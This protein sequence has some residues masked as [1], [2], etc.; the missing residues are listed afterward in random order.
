[1]PAQPLG[2]KTVS[3]VGNEMNSLSCIPKPDSGF[4]GVD[5]KKEI[6]LLIYQKTFVHY[7][8]T[9]LLHRWLSW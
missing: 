2:V 3:Q 6:W 9:P 4:T 7:C 8:M 5:L 1:M